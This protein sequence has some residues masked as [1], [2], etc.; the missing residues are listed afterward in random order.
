MKGKL[1]RDVT[2]NECFWLDKDY[3]KGTALTL[4]T[5]HTFGCI[6]DYGKPV[7]LEDN[8]FFLEI[9]CDAIDWE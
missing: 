3:K 6:S 2:T 4:F 1:N 8:D 7:I 9:P 5:D